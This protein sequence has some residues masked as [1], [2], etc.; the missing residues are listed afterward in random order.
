MENAFDYP[1]NAARPAGDPARVEGSQ[2]VAVLVDR[3]SDRAA[4]RDCRLS[5]HQDT[6]FADSG[7]Q[8]YLRC[9][10]LGSVD[11]VFGAGLFEHGSRGP[12]AVAAPSRSVLTDEQARYRVAEAVLRGWTPPR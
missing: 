6:L 5:G 12:G 9:E 8:L 2:A 7:R 4:F 1:A 10:I 3:G 11:F